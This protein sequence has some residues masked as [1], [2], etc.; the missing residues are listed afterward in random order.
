MNSYDPKKNIG[1]GISTPV[2]FALAENR[3]ELTISAIVFSWNFNE[4]K[5][6]SNTTQSLLKYKVSFELE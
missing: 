6:F 2:R 4:H 3:I 5:C 1:W